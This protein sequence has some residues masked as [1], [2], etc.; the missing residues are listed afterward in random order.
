MQNNLKFKEDIKEI[1]FLDEFRNKYGLEPVI[2]PENNLNYSP[3]FTKFKHNFNKEIAFINKNHPF[4]SIL[5]KKVK[6]L[7]DIFPDIALIANNE[8]QVFDDIYSFNLSKSEPNLNLNKSNNIS[9]S[10]LNSNLYSIKKE[11]K[12]IDSNLNEITINKSNTNED[13]NNFTSQQILK[14]SNYNIINNQDNLEF[15]NFNIDNTIDNTQIN[16]FQIREI[17]TNPISPIFYGN[18]ISNSNLERIANNYS[19]NIGQ[20]SRQSLEYSIAN[21]ISFRPYYSIQR[22]N[23]N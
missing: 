12:T 10:N 19:N 8:T 14:P 1:D 7:E 23:F 16:N 9:K 11:T 5:G 15:N 21:N 17:I 22:R 20:N 3:T 2:L 6:K 18:N 4:A 13:S